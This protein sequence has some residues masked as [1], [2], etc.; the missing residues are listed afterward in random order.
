MICVI[1]DNKYV[2]LFQVD[3][4]KHL[5]DQTLS[6]LEIKLPENFIR[7]QKS[8]IVNKEKIREIHKHFNG[9]FII[10]MDDKIQTRITTG[11]TFYSVIK[12]TLG[13]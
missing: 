1:A 2:F 7:V 11:L 8:F 9:R 5:I 12:E 13:I 6:A 4:K 10:I 3:G